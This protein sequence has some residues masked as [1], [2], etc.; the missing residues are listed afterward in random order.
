MV[1]VR[2]VQWAVAGVQL[3]EQAH[4]HPGKSNFLSFFKNRNRFY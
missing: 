3:F 4:A 1:D 2:R